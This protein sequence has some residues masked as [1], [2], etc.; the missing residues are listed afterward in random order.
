M[1]G[2]VLVVEDHV[3]VAIG[4]QLALSARGWDVQTISGPTA[5]DVVAHAQRFQPQG[6]LLDIHIGGDVGSGIEL[7]GPLLSTGAQVVMLT[8]ESRRMVLA[9]CLEAGASGWIGKGATLDEVDSTLCHVVA[10]GTM[11][12]RTDRAELLDELRL[13]RAGTVRAHATF[14]RLTQREAIVLGALVDGLSAD[15][16]AGAHFVALTTVRSQIRAVLH[17]LGVRSQLAAVAFASAH[18]ELLPQLVGVGRDMRRAH[19]RGRRGG[20]GPDCR[21]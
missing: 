8:A 1:S 20:P 21:R 12:G 13:E 16:I 2:R 5:L 19:P 9:E 18:P 6:V 17:K 3:L 11:I 14:E 15:E 10:G 4:L 7:I